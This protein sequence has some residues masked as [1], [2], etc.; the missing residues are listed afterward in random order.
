MAQLG[1]GLVGRLIGA[2]V[3]I[4]IA[5]AIGFVWN[6]GSDKV[7]EAK[8]PDVGECVYFEKDGTNDKTVDA[9]CG[10]AK[11]S[12]KVVSDEGDC[13]PAEV[14]FTISDVGSASDAIVDLCLV[15]D[16]KAGDCFDQTTEDKVDCA[17]TAGEATVVKVASVGKAGDDCAT[18][19][20]PQEYT[21]RDIL[22]CLVPNA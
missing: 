11:S 21:K 18:P 5:L 8:A 19:G 14:N 4:A 20:L 9:D 13:G 3:A 1:K 15:L 10:D 2:G 17:A 6:K 22:L 16:V 12:H 7:A